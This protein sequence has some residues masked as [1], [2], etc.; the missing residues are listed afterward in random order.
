LLQGVKGSAGRCRVLPGLTLHQ[1]EG[2][3][4]DEAEAILRDGAS[5]LV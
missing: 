3:Y 2:S 4:T 5:L 1:P